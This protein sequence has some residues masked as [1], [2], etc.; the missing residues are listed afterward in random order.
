MDSQ[1]KQTFFTPVG[2]VGGTVAY[3]GEPITSNAKQAA[4][5]ADKYLKDSL[6][7]NKL[8]ERVYELLLQDLRCQQ[9][10]FSNYSHQRWL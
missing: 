4:K 10:R 3:G 1:D 8:T 2:E 5:A 6:L 9:E 7:L